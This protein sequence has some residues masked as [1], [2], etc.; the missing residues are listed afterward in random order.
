[1]RFR[2]LRIAWS[3]GW[4]IL[5]VLLIVLW[6][7]SYW[8]QDSVTYRTANLD[9]TIG[10]GQSGLG[11]IWIKPRMPIPYRLG[12]SARSRSIDV[13]T[14]I[15]GQRFVWGKTN[16]VIWVPGWLLVLVAGLSSAIPWL[17]WP[18]RFSLRTLLI[19]TTLVAG[20]MGLIVWSVR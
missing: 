1:M 11:F 10:S 3:V 15:K 8:Y 17:H 2:K 4:G 5:C 6:V 12:M 14:S 19:A 13:A 16:G 9:A 20:A 7:R 18:R